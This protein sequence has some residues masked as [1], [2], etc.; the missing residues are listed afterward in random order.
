MIE[1]SLLKKEQKEHLKGEV[2]QAKR[3]TSTGMTRC[4]FF[5]TGLLR[6]HLGGHGLAVLIDSYK[7]HNNRLN[8]TFLSHNS[9]C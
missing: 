2:G 3:G 5:K 4:G 9:V 8:R 6:I 1:T 7:L